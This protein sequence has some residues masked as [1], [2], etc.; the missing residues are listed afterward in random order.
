M[1]WPSPSL[2]LAH[3]VDLTAC[4]CQAAL[5]LASLA[6]SIFWLVESV[7]KNEDSGEKCMLPLLDNFPMRS[8]CSP[9]W[10]SPFQLPLYVIYL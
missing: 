5:R 6:L 2:C 9:S 10:N 7:V 4:L 8:I 3:S 1:F